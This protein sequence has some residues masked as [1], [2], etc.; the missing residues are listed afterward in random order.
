MRI[1]PAPEAPMLLLLS[2]HGLAQAATITVGPSGRDHTS[3]QVAID[4]AAPGDRIEVD[5]GTY[6]ENLSVDFEVTLVGTGGAAS[7]FV[8]AAGPVVSVTS[9]GDLTL[10][11][12]TVQPSAERGIEV[13]QGAVTL[14][15][16]TVEGGY[17]TLDA[18]GGLYA[19]EADVTISG[20]T[21]DGNSASVFHGGNLYAY[22]STVTITGSDFTGG[23]AEKGGGIY[24]FG[25]TLT[26]T[27]STLTGNEVRA[28]DESSRGGG[29]RSQDATI[30]VERCTFDSSIAENGYGG[31]IATSGGDLTIRDSVFT[32]NAISEFYG[33]AIAAYDTDLVVEGSDFATNEALLFNGGGNAHGGAII[34]YGTGVATTTIEGSSFSENFAEGFGGALRIEAGALTVT[35]STFASNLSGYGGAMHLPTP[36]EVTISGSTFTTNEAPYAGAIRW[37]PNSSTAS[38]TLTSNTFDGNVADGGYAGA[39]FAYSGGSLAL[40]GNT[41]TG[42]TA[43]VGGAMLLQLVDRI[44]AKQNLFC[45]NEASGDAGNSDGG[46]VTV[47]QSGGGGS[48][49]WTNNVFA[50]NSAQA[51]GGGINFLEALTVYVVNNTFVENEA[52]GNGGAAIFRSSPAQ[53]T[54]NVVAWSAGNGVTADAASSLTITYNDFYDNVAENTGDALDPTLLDASNLKLDP[55]LTAYTANGDCSDDLFWPLATSPLVDAGD[56]AISDPD[57]S[58]SDIGAFGGPDA[59]VSLFTDTDGDGWVD[60]QDC[61]PEDDNA[62]PGALE[63]PYD[64]IDQDCDGEDEIDV[65]GDAWTAVEAGGDDCDDTNAAV[66]PGAE[67]TWYDGVDADCDG[68]DDH[69]QDADGSPS[70]ADCDDLDPNVNPAAS[71]ALGDGVDA[72]CDGEDGTEVADTGDGTD[73]E[74]KGCNCDGGAGAPTG[75]WALLLLALVR[76]RR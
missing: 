32:H 25:G 2:V 23:R 9:T 52:A 49:R 41:F 55:A 44:T 31:A 7:T 21:F 36:A 24:M 56:P 46:A 73:E 66:N 59:D 61:Q 43:V 48:N 71:D 58:R 12:V 4:A 47:Y 37:R 42:N 35:D 14:T 50:E 76:R 39:V 26:L 19:V 18:G 16:V 57:A 34:V 29:I 10:E 70:P 45:H 38:L 27:D 62:F 74:D 69:D 53:F 30:V 75:A 67:E 65:D 51:Y 22:A 60:V 63:T 40:T 28:D 72:N 68:A 11:G 17:S 3:I 6:A 54:N 20:S 8:T 13:R 15:D 33:G 1:S 5:P 64:G